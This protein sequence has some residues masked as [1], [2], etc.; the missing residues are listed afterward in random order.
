MDADDFACQKD[1]IEVFHSFKK[2]KDTKRAYMW[3]LTPQQRLAILQHF[4]EQQW[5]NLARGKIEKVFEFTRAT[6]RANRLESD[7]ENSPKA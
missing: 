6:S 4:R 7:L 5:G 1:V 3:S 2:L